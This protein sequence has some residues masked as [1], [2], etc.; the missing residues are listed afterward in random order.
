MASSV[1]HQ[2]QRHSTHG[3]CQPDIPLHLV[4]CDNSSNRH[5]ED[6]VFCRSLVIWLAGHSAVP[7]LSLSL[8]ASSWSSSGEGWPFLQPVTLWSPLSSNS[9][10]SSLFGCRFAPPLVFIIGSLSWP[11]WREGKEQKGGQEL[12]QCCS[13]KGTLP[14]G[15]HSSFAP[16][17]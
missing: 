8:M 10:P 11:M 17:L 5:C 9:V 14:Q 15:N 6:C 2:S 13:L 12:Q 16:Q 4:A 7:G 1:F 3:S